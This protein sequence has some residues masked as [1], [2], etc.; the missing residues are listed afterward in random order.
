VR[1]IE[2]NPDYVKPYYDSGVLFSDL[3]FNKEAIILYN[4]ALELDPDY[5]EAYYNLAVAHFHNKQYKLAIEYCD[6]AGEIG[7]DNAA[8][9]KALKPY[10]DKEKGNVK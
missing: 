5:N 3:G 9:I 6:K 8:L 7:V 1:A 10:R 2:I 4:K